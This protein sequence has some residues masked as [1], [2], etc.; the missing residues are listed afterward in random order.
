MSTRRRRAKAPPLP[1]AKPGAHTEGATLRQQLAALRGDLDYLL[2]LDE[3]GE[4]LSADERERVR[5][6]RVLCQ[7]LDGPEGGDR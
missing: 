3:R 7:S 4:P 5:A 6:W 2:F 1:R